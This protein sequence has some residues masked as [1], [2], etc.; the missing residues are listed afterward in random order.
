MLVVM[1]ICSDMIMMQNTVCILLAYRCAVL[2]ALCFGF[3]LSPY[4]R[5]TASVLWWIV[6]FASFVVLYVLPTWQA[7]IGMEPSVIICLNNDII[8][9]IFINSRQC[10]IYQTVFELY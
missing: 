2:L 4:Y 6:G 10:E 7:F 5:I 1:L 9:I 8:S 3:I